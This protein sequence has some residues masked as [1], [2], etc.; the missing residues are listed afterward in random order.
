MD[1]NSYF[2]IRPSPVD[3]SGMASCL[4][5]NIKAAAKKGFHNFSGLDNWKGTHIGYISMAIFSKETSLSAGI[6]SFLFKALSR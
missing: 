3:Q 1:G 2:E 6:G 5:M 4:M